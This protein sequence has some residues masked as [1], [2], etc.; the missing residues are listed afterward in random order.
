[1]IKGHADIFSTN[2]YFEKKKIEPK[3]LRS[4]GWF[5]T[6]PIGMGTHLGD[7]SDLDSK[8]Y[9][10]TLLYGIEN[11]INFIDTAINYR[12]MRSEKDVGKTLYEAINVKKIVKREE[13]IISTKCGLILGD[14]TEGLRPSAYLD[15]I[16]KPLGI[17][18]DA[19]SVVNDWD[20]HTL[21]PAFY[22]YAISKSKEN[23]G[24]E[25]IDIHYIHIPEISRYALGEEQFYNQL[26]KLFYF[27]ETQVAKNNVRFYGL[28]SEVSFLYDDTSRWYISLEKV[29]K[30]AEEVA[31]KAHHLKFIQLQY[32]YIE[33]TAATKKYQKI[34]SR[35]VTALESAHEL[36]INVIVN[37]PLNMGNIPKDV[38]VDEMLHFVTD[39]PH[40]LST[41]VGSK[42]LEHLASNLKGYI[43]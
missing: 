29:C 28:A 27:Y 12:G 14:I 22:E 6:L 16:L 1:M 40:I 37:M 8:K 23:L 24:I 11:G 9:I 19:F 33:R 41:M 18:E 7:F 39:N 38:S 43:K 25:T 32:N 4:I 15:Q 26:R 30:I 21:M 17:Q 3:L 35:Q 10:Q 13:L 20:R 36:G 34:S 31:G 2:L 42:N 5:S